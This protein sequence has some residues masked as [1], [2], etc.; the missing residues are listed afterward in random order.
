M[1]FCKTYVNETDIN[2]RLK[3]K[4]VYQM[5]IS[6]V[7]GTGSL[8]N[9]LYAASSSNVTDI[10]NSASDTSGL[11]GIISINSSAEETIASSEISTDNQSSPA[12]VLNPFNV[13]NI[14]NALK[15]ISVKT[16][17]NSIVNINDYSTEVFSQSQLSDVDQI[18]NA[19]N[20][21]N[22]SSRVINLDESVKV[23]IEEQETDLDSGTTYSGIT[24]MSSIL[25]NTYNYYKNQTEKDTQAKVDVEI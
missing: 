20:Q 7:S 24:D 11:D 25:T 12:Q 21:I 9:T 18:I 2:N 14:S 8:Y 15:A 4:G 16:D 6:S 1:K 3:V 5:S 23:A 17:F 22:S 19:E 13:N 10:V